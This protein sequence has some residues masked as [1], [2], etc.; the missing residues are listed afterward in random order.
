ME[1]AAA[2]RTGLPINIEPDVL[3]RQMRR[4]ARPIGPG[5]WRLRALG[6]SRW[7]GGF[8]PRDIGVKVF[9]T[10]LQLIV[11]EPFGA[12]TKLAALQ[13]LNN[14]PKTFDL[15]LCLSEVAAFGRERSYH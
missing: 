8:D 9:K 4:Q 5:S 6:R 12:P 7:K 10:E 11:I 1:T 14:E 3:A 2:T 13:F 15:C